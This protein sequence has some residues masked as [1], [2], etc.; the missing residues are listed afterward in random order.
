MIQHTHTSHRHIVRTSHQHTWCAPACMCH[1]HPLCRVAACMRHDPRVAASP[2]R[3]C[4]YASQRGSDATMGL[5]RRNSPCSQKTEPSCEQHAHE[6]EHAQHIPWRGRNRHATTN[7]AA[8]RVGVSRTMCESCAYSGADVIRQCETDDTE[9]PGEE[10]EEGECRG[11]GGGF[12]GGAVGMR[13]MPCSLATQIN[14]IHDET[15]EPVASSHP[16]M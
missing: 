6:H 11:G 8:C 13:R 9:L 3:T 12:G 4:M 10:E 2:L 16:C 5:P 14:V 1:S 15:R 7:T